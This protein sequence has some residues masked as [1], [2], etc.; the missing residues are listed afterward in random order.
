MSKKLS[1]R[2]TMKGLNTPDF[3]KYENHNNCVESK[4]AVVEKAWENY[5]HARDDIEPMTKQTELLQVALDASKN[6]RMFVILS[7]RHYN[8]QLTLKK[9]EIIA[10]TMATVKEEDRDDELKTFFKTCDKVKTGKLSEKTNRYY[11]SGRFS[12]INQYKWFVQMLQDNMTL[13]LDYDLFNAV[14]DELEL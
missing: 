3:T 5:N 12:S 14:M 2:E 7:E 10:L 8:P 6:W 9:L 1:F 13:L 11:D 4:I